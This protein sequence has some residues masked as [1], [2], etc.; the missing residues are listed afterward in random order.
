MF[1]IIGNWIDPRRIDDDRA[2]VT[3]G[4]LEARVAMVPVGARLNDRE[5]VH[6]GLTGLNA[7]KTYA[8]N[9]VHLEWNQKPVPVDRSVLIEFVLY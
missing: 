4:L 2:V 9:T 6:K 1:A 3:L 8:R 7:R 5:F